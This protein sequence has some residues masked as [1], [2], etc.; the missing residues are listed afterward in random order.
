MSAAQ[1]TATAHARRCAEVVKAGSFAALA[2][3][4]RWPIQARFWLEWGT[5]FLQQRY[6][7]FN[8]RNYPQFVEKLRYLHRNPVKAGLCERPEDWQWSSFRHYANRL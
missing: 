8:V 3:Q 6:Y 4:N 5:S 2:S 1:Q 7:D